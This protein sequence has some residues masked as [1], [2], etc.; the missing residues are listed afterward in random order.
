MK[1]IVILLLSLFA[2]NVNT[3]TAA[4]QQLIIVIPETKQTVEELVYDCY[5]NVGKRL[6]SDNLINI[7]ADQFA[8]YATIVAY[9]ESELNP[10]SNKLD[11][12]G[13]A[14]ITKDTRKSLGIASMKNMSIEEQINSHEKFFRKCS[15]KALKLIH[16]STD[17][18]ALNF[19]PS[20]MHKTKLSDVTNKYLAALDFN[21]DN[22]ITRDDLYLYQ[23]KKVKYNK[24]I[25]DLFNKTNNGQK[26]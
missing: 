4:K 1:Y 26:L 8:T 24:Y 3:N 17:F 13:I 9:C 25:S 23:T 7:S 11:Q 14:Q 12:Q 6:I 22:I 10:K 18:H 19:A 16:S 15:K 20:R 5:Y 21:K 2:Y